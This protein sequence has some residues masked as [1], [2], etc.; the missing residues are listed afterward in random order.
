VS[1]LRD[2]NDEED[3][4]IWTAKLIAEIR[5][6]EEAKSGIS[7]FLEKTPPPWRIKP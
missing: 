5:T 7:A 1:R 6:T 4:A 3:P 2:K